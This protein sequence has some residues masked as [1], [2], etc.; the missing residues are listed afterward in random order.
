[1]PEIIVAAHLLGATLVWASAWTLIK[2]GGS[3][4]KLRRV[5]Q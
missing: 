5:T 1:L 3:G 4:F 2:V